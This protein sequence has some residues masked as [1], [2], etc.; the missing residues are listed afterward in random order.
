MDIY[1]KIKN[2]QS[3]KKRQTINYKKITFLYFIPFIIIKGNTTV[4][5]DF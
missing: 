2:V 3:Q 4:Y 5:N 1:K